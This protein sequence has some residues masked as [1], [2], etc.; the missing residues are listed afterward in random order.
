[1]AK[2]TLSDI[3]KLIDERMTVSLNDIGIESI[4]SANTKQR[5]T[6]FLEFYTY[7]IAKYLQQFDDDLIEEGLSCD[8]SGDLNIDFVYKNDDA[9]FI[10]QSKYKGGGN[11]LTR[12]EIAGFSK[13]QSRINDKEYF[14]KNANDSVKELLYDVSK[15]SVIHY[16]LLT[17]AKVPQT[18][19]D[20]FDLITNEERER[21]C[22]YEI[23]YELKALSEIKDDIKNANSINDPIPEEVIIPVEKINNHF[24]DNK[25]WAYVDLSDL[26][27][28]D[29]NYETILTTIKG[30]EL[31]RL[32]RQYRG[33]LFNYNIR[34]YLGLNVINKKM[35]DTIENNPQLFY[36][37]NNGV[38]AICSK[39]SL[40]K[41][42][43]GKGLRI[44][45]KDFQIINGAQ[46]TCTIGQ[47]KDDEP[48]KDVRVLLRITKTEDIKKA[49][50]LNKE[51]ITFNNSQTVIKA[52][53]FRSND[54]IQSYIESNTKRYLY[55]GITPHEKL[56]YLPKRMKY[57]KK[58][59]EAYLSMETLAKILYVFSY[60]PTKIYATSKFL[61]DTDESSNGMY[62]KVFGDDGEE[63]VIYTDERLKKIIATAFLWM[64]LNDKL[65]EKAKSVLKEKGETI[66]YQT[67]LAKWHFFWAYGTVMRL[68]YPDKETWFV[69][70][71]LDGKAFNG[72]F[73]DTWFDSITERIQEQIEDEYIESKPT[74]KEN[75]DSEVIHKGFNF[76][77]WLRNLKSFE[78]LKR[79]FNRAR[80]TAFPID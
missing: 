30:T 22:D 61:F 71:I 42:E 29:T 62:W 74:E 31:K 64:Y 68:L 13:I 77:N 67:Y 70:R 4:K 78:K 66:E 10:Y 52:S 47:Y 19:R 15:K 6:A 20:E 45:A 8:Y 48:L 44:K 43:S 38:S 17:N 33:R 53:D 24:S 11:Q 1:M 12:D 2:A 39:L 57:K 54:E 7:E 26:L 14:D 21:Y 50:G 34:G 9:Y 37:F 80:K 27:G 3:S 72:S 32:H 18:M 59:G 49:K 36:L 23:D 60:E 46:T 28:G 16:I 63:C 58:K 35:K 75:E 55:R 40:D 25:Q 5:G 79:K 65:K 41:S 73:L 51:I 56:V 76:K 69:N